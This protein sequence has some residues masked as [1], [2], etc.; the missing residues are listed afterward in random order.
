MV[1]S[2]IASC[3]VKKKYENRKQQAIR[4]RLRGF[5]NV[6]FLIAR[7]IEKSSILSSFSIEKI[8][9]WK[10]IRVVKIAFNSKV[11]VKEL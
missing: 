6:G 3:G 7:I 1:P 11:E 10:R 4:I 9:I 2:W 5:G 8:P